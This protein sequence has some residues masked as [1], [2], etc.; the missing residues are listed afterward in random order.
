MFNNRFLKLKEDTQNIIHVE[1]ANWYLCLLEG[2]LTFHA[3]VLEE[4][5]AEFRDSYILLDV[6]NISEKME[7]T[8]AHYEGV[9]W[10]L[11]HVQG[12]NFH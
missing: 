3:Q 9:L 10:G 1:A 4:V 6:Y 12:F 7:L 11:H 8:H 2:T 5:F